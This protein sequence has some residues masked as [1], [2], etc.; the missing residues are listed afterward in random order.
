MIK[1]LQIQSES[2]TRVVSSLGKD[3]LIELRLA[4]DLLDVGLKITFS[5]TVLWFSL[6]CENAVKLAI[7]TSRG[8]R[9]SIKPLL[10]AEDYNSC[11]DDLIM[12]TSVLQKE[13]FFK[14]ASHPCHVQ[15]F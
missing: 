9:Q 11:L 6:R 4:G 7:E 1:K 15:Q 8:S 3:F 10:E 12:S 13:S 2:P 14:S 5:M